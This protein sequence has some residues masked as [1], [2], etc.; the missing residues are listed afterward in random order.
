M[1]DRTTNTTFYNSTLPDRIA[2]K[3]NASDGDT[4]DIP[5][6]AG[7][8]VL[9][10]NSEDNDDTIASSTVSGKTVTLG[11]IDD[12]GSAE[13]TDTDINGEVILTSQ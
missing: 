8:I 12:A 6:G 10:M 1:A 7:L 4:F 3:T 9:G 13:G 11:L 2:F 5:F